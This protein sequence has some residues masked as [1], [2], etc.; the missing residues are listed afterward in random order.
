MFRHPSKEG[1]WVGSGGPRGDGSKWPISRDAKF[2]SQRPRH[3]DD[4]VQAIGQAIEADGDCDTCAAI[5]G[6]LMALKAPHTVPSTW[7][8]QLE[9]AL[10]A[11]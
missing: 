7:K 8:Q 1:P 5:T 3:Y 4:Y 2:S 11:F 9:P 6:A 10:R